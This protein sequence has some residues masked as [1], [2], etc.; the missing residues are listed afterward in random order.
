[1]QKHEPYQPISAEGLGDVRARYPTVPHE[2]VDG[3]VLLLVNPKDQ[4]LADDIGGWWLIIDAADSRVGALHSQLDDANNPVY[5][6]RAEQVERHLSNVLV[7]SRKL[8]VVH[9]VRINYVNDYREKCRQHDE[10]LERTLA[11]IRS[12]AAGHQ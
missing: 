11:A 2:A 1:L 5:L 12:R 8:D 6:D 3:G 10:K 4:R 9:L 7:A